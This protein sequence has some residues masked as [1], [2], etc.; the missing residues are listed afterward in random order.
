MEKEK[1]LLS[2]KQSWLFKIG[3]FLV[4]LGVIGLISYVYVLEGQTYTKTA[5]LIISLIITLVGGIAWWSGWFSPFLKQSTKDRHQMQ[6]KG[7]LTD[8][9]KKLL[10]R[11]PAYFRGIAFSFIGGIILVFGLL[12][13]Q[14]EQIEIGTTLAIVAVG[15][16]VVGSVLSMYGVWEV[17][18]VILLIFLAIV[19]ILVSIVPI[20]YSVSLFNDNFKHTAILRNASARTS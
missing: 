17:N 3:V 10:Q 8:A 11:H 4:I 5:T 14:S 19:F 16:M 1:L 6:S 2:T 9:E 18:K 15:L 7:L 13:L 20:V 12:L